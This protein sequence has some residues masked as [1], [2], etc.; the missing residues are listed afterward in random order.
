V[1]SRVDPNAFVASLSPALRQA[2][3]IARA[4]E[5]TVVNSPKTGE[6]TPTKAALTIADAA[7]QEALL[8]PLFE[9]FPFVTL[10]AE[11]DT[12]AV[13]RFPAT[14][15]ALVVIDPIDGTLRSYLEGRGPYAVIVGLV[16]R[17]RV[18]AG[19]VALPREGLFFDAV[20]GEG[21]FAAHAG[22]IRRRAL[23]HGGAR[24]VL[25][26][27]EM[28]ESVQSA[29]RARGYELATGAGGAIA[30]APLVA[31]VCAGLRVAP[32]ET[33]TISRRGRIGALIAEEAGAVV[34]D[35]SGKR[36]PGDVDAPAR[37]LIVAATPE[38]GRD[39]LAALESAG[40]L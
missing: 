28:P 24:R 36:F 2:A 4:L 21:A 31:G 14:G 19:L 16:T 29:L 12:P 34:W 32:A 15:D 11:E 7:S 6:V 33:R 40:A 8:V 26:S 9:H 35:E 25:V 20:R 37:A 13:R 10:D 39:L 18:E 22:G 17:G 27:H 1:P 5:G 3:A 23:R 30:V 38:Q